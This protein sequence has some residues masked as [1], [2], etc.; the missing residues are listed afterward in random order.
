MGPRSHARW[1]SRACRL[2]R[3]LGTE[4]TMTT[5]TL[6]KLRYAYDAL[7]PYVSRRILELHHDQHHAAYVKNANTVIAELDRAR[8]AGDLSKLAG[9]ERS[10][11]FNLG[12]HILHSIF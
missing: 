2:L 4:T 7:E 10:L 8:D 6:P 9:L 5:Y 12:G 11:A 3:T 1:S